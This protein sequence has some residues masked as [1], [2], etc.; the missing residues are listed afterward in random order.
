MYGF[1]DERLRIHYALHILSKSVQLTQ[2]CWLCG[3]SGKATK[4]VM[5][6]K[7]FWFCYDFRH[8]INKKFPKDKLFAEMKDTFTNMTNRD[9]L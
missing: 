5:D 9:R 4:L 1:L 8:H 2:E 3:A 7:G 6:K